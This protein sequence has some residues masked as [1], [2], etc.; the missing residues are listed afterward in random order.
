MNE[1]KNKIVKDDQE[2]L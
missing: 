1:M 2:D